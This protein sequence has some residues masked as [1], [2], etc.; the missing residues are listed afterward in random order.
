[1]N[2]NQGPLPWYRKDSEDIPFE[3][4]KIIGPSKAEP[5][6]RAVSIFPWSQRDYPN[7]A[8]LWLEWVDSIAFSS[9]STVWVI[10]QDGYKYAARVDVDIDTVRHL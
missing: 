4:A 3:L 1:M 9:K 5:G 10:R 7:D 6:Y 8:P 2:A